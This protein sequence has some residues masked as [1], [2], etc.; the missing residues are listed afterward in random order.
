[1]LKLAPVAVRGVV[2]IRLLVVLGVFLFMGL[3]F[4]GADHGQFINPPRPKTVVSATKSQTRAVFVPSEP[5]VQQV[6]PE[7][8]TNLAAEPVAPPL[9]DLTTQQ[10]PIATKLMH[11]PGG[12]SV[13]S[14]PGREFPVVGA[15][16]VGGVVM[17]ADDASAPGWVRIQ[18]DGLGEGWVAATLLRE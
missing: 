13:R 4:L 8:V 14:G 5:I 12:A 11:V 15:L 17:V 6:V 3:W 2:V 18:V 1:M 7:L 16:A 9:P 10:Q